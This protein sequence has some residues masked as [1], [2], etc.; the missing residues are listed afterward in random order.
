VTFEFINNIITMEKIHIIQ[1]A[2]QQDMFMFRR[3]VVVRGVYCG[4]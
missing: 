2:T 4:N 3:I 1:K